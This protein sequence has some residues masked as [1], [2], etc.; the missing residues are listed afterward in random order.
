VA[1]VKDDSKV[2]LDKSHYE[3]VVDLLIK[4]NKLQTSETG[5]EGKEGT[6]SQADVYT[7]GDLID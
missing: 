4:Q 6:N 1:K 5:K 2:N 7:E 3:G